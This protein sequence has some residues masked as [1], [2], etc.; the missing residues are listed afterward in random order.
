MN[1][2]IL[3]CYYI[4]RFS[5]MRIA[6]LMRLSEADIWNEIAENGYRYRERSNSKVRRTKQK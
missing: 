3:D 4:S 1:K 5:T 6:R 2:F